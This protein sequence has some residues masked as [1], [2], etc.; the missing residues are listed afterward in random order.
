MKR[1]KVGSMTSKNAKSQCTI[2][3]KRIIEGEIEEDE[4]DDKEIHVAEV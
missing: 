4:F 2:K 3:K 1:W